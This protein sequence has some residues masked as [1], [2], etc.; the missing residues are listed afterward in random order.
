MQIPDPTLEHQW[1][2]QLV[3]EWVYEM[4]SPQGPDGE[5]SKSTGT[6]TVRMIGDFWTQG[7]L[8]GPMPGGKQ[9]TCITTIGYDTTKN[10]FVGTWIGSPMTYMFLYEGALDDDRRILTLNTTGPDFADPTK[11]ATYQDIIEMQDK[12]TRILR[13]QFQ[14]DQGTWHEFMRATYKRA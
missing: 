4:D 3:G 6:E 8:R 5:P 13:S 9:M 11:T 14:D 12:N 7:E 10:A 1:L 2:R